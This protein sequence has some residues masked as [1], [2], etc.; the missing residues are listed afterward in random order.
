MTRATESSLY[1]LADQVCDGQLA[2]VLARY[3]EMGLSI[4]DAQTYLKGEYGVDVS[5]PTVAKWLASAPM[6]ETAA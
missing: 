6:P 2:D 1:R 5:V 3:N 4:R